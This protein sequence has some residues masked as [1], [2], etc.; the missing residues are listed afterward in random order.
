MTSRGPWLVLAG[1]IGVAAVLLA[2]TQA[3]PA[4]S[5]EHSSSSDGRNGT[6]ALKQFATA[7]GRPGGAVEGDF[8]LP[9]RP[10]LLFV[11]SP[12]VPFS[13]SD[14]AELQHWI[15][16]GGTLVYTAEQG[17]PRLDAA[18]GLRR[19]RRPA[20]G[21]AQAVPELVKGVARL[22]GN[23]LAPA[24]LPAPDQ[25][26]ILR[27]AAGDVLAISFRIQ[28]GRVVVLADPD[29]LTNQHL[30]HADNWRLA[31]DLISWSPRGAPAVF[32]EYHHGAI[33]SGA[34]NGWA[35]APWGDALLWAA[36]VLF[37][38][39]AL[40]GRGF[41]P[42]LPAEAR[43]ERPS[44]EYVAAVGRL[45]RRS[46]ARGLTTEVLLNATRRSL[47]ERVG[48]G[49]PGANLTE[50]LG[51]RSPHLAGELARVQRGAE[52]AA[53]SDEGLRQVAADMHD[54]AYPST[55]TAPTLPSPRDGRRNQE[56]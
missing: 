42:R 15:G 38:G 16:V 45:L 9:E 51:R 2:I 3:G 46:R 12:T 23:Q 30:D 40:R 54:L 41:G 28:S 24:F 32:D 10:G 36:L 25:V 22:E 35:L 29:L 31:A 56:R 55:A 53:L 1:L 13:A 27:A 44:S 37:L 47:A 26:P 48:L 18:L 6:S 14:I 34:G 7:L 50:V 4:D 49:R 39:F 21:S 20:I 19:A 5:P 8:R 17:D 52:L 43:G 33:A 11:F